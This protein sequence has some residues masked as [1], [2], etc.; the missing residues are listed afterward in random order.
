[1]NKDLS[2][3]FGLGAYKQK[4]WQMDDNNH[5]IVFVHWAYRYDQT[6]PESSLKCGIS[7]LSS[8]FPSSLK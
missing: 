4:Q 3:S 6:Y 7:L 1:M 8:R 5:S 2:S